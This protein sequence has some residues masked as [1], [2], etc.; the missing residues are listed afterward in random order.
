[1]KFGKLTFIFLTILGLVLYSNGAETEA[2]EKGKKVTPGIET[3]LDKHVDWVKGKKVGLIT[4]PTGVD[5]NLK[6]DIDLLFEHPDVNLTALFGPEHGIRGDQEAGKYIESYVDEKTGLPVYSL[7]GPTWK[8]TKDMVKDV[9]VLL[10][11]IQDI[12]SNVYTY[13]YTLGFAMEAAAEFDKELIVLDR[14]NPIGGEK[15][16]GPLRS[17]DTVSFMGR[18]L[19][20][21]RH[22]MTVGELATMWNHEYSMGVNLKVSKMKGWK[23]TMHY[24]DTGLPWVQPSPNIPTKESAYLYAGTELL[25]DTTLSVGLG[26]TKPFELV[27]APWLDGEALAQEMKKRNIDGVTFRPAYYTPMF[28]KY[29]GERVGGVQVHIKEP[30]KINLVELGLNLVDAM[31]DQNSDKFEMTSSYANLIGDPEVPTMIKNDEPVNKIID[32]W[33]SELDRWITEVRNQYL[34]YAPFPKK[35]GPYKEKSYLGIL[36]L[37]ISITPGKSVDLKVQGFDKEGKKLEIS[38]SSIDWEVTN[39]IG[40]IEDGIFQPTMEGKGEVIASYKNL[41]AS[42]DVT[43]SV[44]YIEN[45]RYGVHSG[46]T[47]VVLDLNNDVSDYSIEEENGKLFI[48]I[49]YGKIGGDLDREGGIVQ[50]DKSPIV[51][52]IN[53]FVK[54]ESFIAELDL[55]KEGV[56]YNT[57]EFS[58]RL[59]VD[60]A[61]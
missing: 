16:E 48:K 40:K 45:I 57:P 26:T 15:V 61:H 9:D 52:S 5:T 53:Y 10:F 19:L 17:K 7:Y 11:D 60:L 34:L 22:G 37:D 35:T 46:S 42:R 58:S 54:N 28:G 23:R 44:P 51:S 31:R 27:G 59:V 12:G 18:F 38:P 56:K 24:E 55:K 32:S 49:P 4:N 1:M 47:R 30:T 33:Q 41:T 39:N 50:I 8:P 43:V 20:P 3:F 13:I 21:V 2:K 29:S 14:P 36:P 25:D 6:S